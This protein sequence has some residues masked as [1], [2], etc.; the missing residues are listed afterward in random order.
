MSS[1]HAVVFSRCLVVIDSA[2][3]QLGL[4]QRRGGVGHHL[5]YPPSEPGQV[6]DQL[7]Q[8]GAQR[9]AHPGGVSARQRAANGQTDTNPVS[10]DA[11][12]MR[13]GDL[14]RPVL[15]PKTRF[16]ESMYRG[17]TGQR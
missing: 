14:S 15:G 2:R 5:P 7:V 16:G 3:T 1:Y 4:P 8:L 13:A 6:A 9:L 12:F 11:D 17:R 10:A